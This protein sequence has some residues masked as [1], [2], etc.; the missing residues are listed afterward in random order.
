MG[1]G[2]YAIRPCAVEHDGP[3][4]LTASRVPADEG[5]STADSAD[6]SLLAEE[7]V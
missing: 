1:R 7:S 2:R 4:I 3:D 5:V 6:E